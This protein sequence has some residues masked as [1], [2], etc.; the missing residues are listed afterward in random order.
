MGIENP[1]HLLFIAAIALI[2]LGP[3]RLPE[4]ARALGKGIREFRESVEG[5][6]AP[7][8]HAAV[9]PQPAQALDAPTVVAA[10]PQPAPTV[11]PGAVAPAPPADETPGG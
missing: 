2:F 1:V 10:T 7:P 6:S 3:K 4:L 8:E 11:A 5:G 9:P